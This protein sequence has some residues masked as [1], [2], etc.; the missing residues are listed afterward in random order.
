MQHVIRNKNVHRVINALIWLLIFTF[1]PFLLQVIFYNA[2]PFDYF[3]NIHK[4]ELSS[5]DG[6]VL[7]FTTERDALF[8]I[9]ASAIKE[10]YRVGEKIDT[11]I[12]GTKFSKFIFEKHNNDREIGF[13]I[14]WG[15]NLAP[16]EYYA[17]DQISIDLPYAKPKTKTIITNRVTV[18]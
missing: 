11:Q 9:Q 10:V 5:I 1:A 13:N 7:E 17:I 4:Q 6:S 3:V 2:L 15:Y 8:N 14:D 12:S 16:G 18:E